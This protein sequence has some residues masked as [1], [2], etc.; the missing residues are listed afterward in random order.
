M[1]FSFCAQAHLDLHE[2]IDG[3]PPGVWYAG[4]QALGA[5]LRPGDEI[6][7]Y[8]KGVG[9]GFSGLEVSSGL[10]QFIIQADGRYEGRD[11][12]KQGSGGFA[13]S[14]PYTGSIYCIGLGQYA[15]WND[16]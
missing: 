14:E 8:W 16:G 3:C 9:W 5:P 6:V 11:Y 1:S 2:Q 4:E 13:L 7:G 10:N 12:A 15:A